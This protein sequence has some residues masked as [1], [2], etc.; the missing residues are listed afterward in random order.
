MA[1][2]LVPGWTPPPKKKEVYPASIQQYGQ[3]YDDIMGRYRKFLGQGDQQ[4]NQ[5]FGQYQ[6]EFQKG[7]SNDSRNAL[8]NLK[9]LS[10]TGGYSEGDKA[11]LRSRG[12]SPIRSIYANAQQNMDRNRSLGGGYSPNYAASS[13]KM[14]RELSQGISDVTTNVDA[15]IAQNVAQG[16]LSAAPQYAHYASQQDNQKFNS[17]NALQSLYGM[18]NQ[19]TLQGLQG[20]QGM[21]GTTPAGP[22][23][24]GQHM[25][26]Q[27]GQDQNQEQINNSASNSL[28]DMYG[29]LKQRPTPGQFRLG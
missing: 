11:D 9:E 15:G 21:Y 14:A 22:A 19:S 18:K 26:Q 20:M 8:G 5:L 3:D 16:R 13:A 25:F 10:R 17:L 27:R 24:Y 28:M 7:P 2:S 29:R 1:G 6:T 12:I 4:F 23:L